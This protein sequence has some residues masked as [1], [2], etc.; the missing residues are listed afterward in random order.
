M[1][2]NA[3]GISVRSDL[4]PVVPFLFGHSLRQLLEHRGHDSAPHSRL[5]RQDQGDG[6]SESPWEILRIF[7]DPEKLE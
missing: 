5:A 7:R 1:M 6:F 2:V 3:A 4:L